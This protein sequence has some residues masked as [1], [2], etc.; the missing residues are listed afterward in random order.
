MLTK[1]RGT[2]AN[3][4]CQPFPHCHPHESFFNNSDTE[5][6]ASHFVASNKATPTGGGDNNAPPKHRRDVGPH[7]AVLSKVNSFPMKNFEGQVNKKSMLGKDV[8]GADDADPGVWQNV[9][10]RRG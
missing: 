3:N 2:Q 10:Y 4:I 8:R 5:I 9:D 7:K 6:M 1:T